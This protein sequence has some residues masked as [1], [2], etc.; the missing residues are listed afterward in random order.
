[1]Y[2]QVYIFIIQYSFWIA[3]NIIQ[4]LLYLVVLVYEYLSVFTQLYLRKW[5]HLLY[6]R[7]MQLFLRNIRTFHV[8]GGTLILRYGRKVLWWWPPFL[9]LSIQFAPYCMVQPYPIDTLF[10]QKKISLCLSHLVPEIHGHKV[11]LIKQ[12]VRILHQ[13]FPFCIN[14]RLNFRSL[15][16]DLIDPSF[17]QNFRS[18]WVHFFITCRTSL[19]KIWWS[20]PPPQD[21]HL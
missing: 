1:M 11:G 15:V 14:F 6:Q 12:V 8:G 16:L 18:D 3:I 2:V 7:I 17:L 4:Y 5:G 9:W 13:F 19:L 10:L 20:T 21:F